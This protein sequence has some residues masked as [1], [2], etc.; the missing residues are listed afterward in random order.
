MSIELMN[1]TMHRLNL[2]KVGWLREL[3][4]VSLEKAENTQETL[5]RRLLLEHELP[6][7]VRTHVVVV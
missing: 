4:H 6:R 2:S 7:S 5:S 3:F 1:P